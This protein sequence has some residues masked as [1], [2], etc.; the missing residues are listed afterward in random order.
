MKTQNNKKRINKH[1]KVN[2]YKYGN[3]LEM[4]N[5]VAS[6]DATILPLSGNEYVDLSTGEIKQFKNR[7]KL[8]VQSPV[9]LK[10]TFRKLRRII[11]DNFSGGDLWV[12][13]TY[14]Q[15]NG[16][17]MTDTARVY[18][19]FKAFWRRFIA[20]YGSSDYLS[21]SRTAGKW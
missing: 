12:A 3:V 1:T 14:K 5:S 4:T 9:N 13:L 15:D 2:A 11:L 7:N 20:A 21:S 6:H 17:P 18:K 10:K 8:R 16:K 19:D